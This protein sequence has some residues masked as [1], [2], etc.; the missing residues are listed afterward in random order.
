[1]LLFLQK[2]EVIDLFNYLKINYQYGFKQPWLSGLKHIFKCLE[3]AVS[4]CRL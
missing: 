2:N 3:S 4:F 1:M